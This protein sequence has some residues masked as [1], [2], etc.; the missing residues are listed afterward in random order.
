MFKFVPV[1]GD[2]IEEIDIG[3]VHFLM[4]AKDINLRHM[5]RL[6]YGKESTRKI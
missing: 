3:K 2:R 6:M 4:Q 1:D 5:V